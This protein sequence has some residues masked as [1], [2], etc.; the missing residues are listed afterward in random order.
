MLLPPPINYLLR[1]KSTLTTI[2]KQESQFKDGS[3][4]TGVKCVPSC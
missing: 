4:R 3:K 2:C 1:N